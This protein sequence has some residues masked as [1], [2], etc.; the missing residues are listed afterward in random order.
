M[1]L[2]TKKKC[3][4]NRKLLHNC[5]NIE[6]KSSNPSWTVSVAKLLEYSGYHSINTLV[7]VNQVH[8]CWMSQDS[9][10]ISLCVQKRD[11]DEALEESSLAVADHYPHI[12]LSFDQPG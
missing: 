2:L 8:L 12:A 3:K 9:F 10:K 6:F 11:Q 4:R 1:E 7:P 5:K